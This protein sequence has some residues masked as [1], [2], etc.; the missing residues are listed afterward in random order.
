MVHKAKNVYIN[1]AEDYTDRNNDVAFVTNQDKGIGNGEWLMESSVSRHM[2]HQRNI[3]N[4][5]KFSTPQQ[6]RIRDGRIVEALGVGNCKL[7]MTFKVSNSK[8]VTMQSVLHIPKLTSNLFS[9]EAATV[10]GNIVQFGVNRCYIRGKSEEL[11][12]MGTRKNDGL[13]Q[14]DCKAS[15]IENASVASNSSMNGLDIWHQRLGHKPEVFEKF[16]EFEKLYS[17]E[18]GE[19]I[20]TLRTGN[21]GEYTSNEFLQYLKSRGIH[22]EMSVAYCP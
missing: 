20:K 16:M 17:N 6:V 4:Y 10:K 19:C 1:V 21:G 7:E 2:T 11:H 15:V 5:H 3:P 14:L 13:Y 9:V 12:G 8:N 18:S 22:H